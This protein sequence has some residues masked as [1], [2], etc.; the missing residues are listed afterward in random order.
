MK[1]IIQDEQNSI[2]RC[3][4]TNPKKFWKY[5]KLKTKNNNKIGSIKYINA[6][7]EDK[8]AVTDE[9]KCNAFV[10][11]FT[12]VF[13]NEPNFNE[14]AATFK[15]FTN[16]ME[17]FDISKD[18]VL[19]KLNN[20]K[21]DKSPGYDNIHPRILYEIRNEI[22]EPLTNL[23]NLSLSKGIL[24]SDWKLSSVTALF[25]KGS[26]SLI[27]NYRPVSLTSIAC[28]ILE[29]II[30]DKIINYLISS[31][32]ISNKQF[33]FIKGRLTSIQLL[34]L[35]D[36]W[37]N[38]LDNNREGVD[39]IYKDFEKAFD[40]VPHKRL[41]FKL[42][43]YGICNTVINWIKSYLKNRKHRVKINNKY[44][45]WKEVTSGIP[46]G[47]VLGPI[48]FIIYINDLPEICPEG[49][50][51]NLFVDDAKMSKTLVSLDDK[52]QL[53]LALNE[54]VNW[55]KEW[56]LS[57]N[58]NKCVALNLKMIDSPNNDYFIDTDSG[59]YKLQNVKLTKDL[60]VIIDNQ[61]TFNEHIAEK[62]K[63]AN[64][65]LGLIKRNFRYL[66]EYTFI[67]LYKSLVRSQ[68]EY[69]SSVWSPYKKGLI[70]EIESMQRRATKLIPKLKNLTYIERLKFLKLSTLKYRRYRGDMIETYKIL[71]NKYDKSVTPTLDL[72]DTNRTRGNNLKL[73][74]KRANH[75]FRKYS[76][77]V[78]VPKIWNS[79][80]NNVVCYKDI[81]SFKINLDKYWSNIEVLYDYK[82]PFS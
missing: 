76:F 35:L 60:G 51:L 5:I 71:T 62:I 18:T 67:L 12:S 57:L 46:Q 13:T 41:I 58:I 50:D 24:P 66:D 25:K 10:N 75:D 14:E 28:K 82:A 77:F 37:T 74:F 45:E 79:L 36:K 55:F 53:Q 26:K 3:C 31:N 29:L 20:L 61:L 38:H 70:D 7:G 72:I 81:K 1:K 54:T 78:R 56:L 19:L 64:C 69:A 23:F 47:S 2:A 27:N 63:K 59:N 9:E 6:T 30:V 8:I 17:E 39:I 52:T 21:I 11:Y 22:F 40:K 16:T 15:T 80:N 73:K 44:S 68:L 49:V 33:G 42:K 65:M 48:L 34:N 32:I 43:K 4:K